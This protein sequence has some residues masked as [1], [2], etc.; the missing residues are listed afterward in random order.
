MEELNREK[1]KQY[2]KFKDLHCYLLFQLWVW[3]LFC[4]NLK[5][6][7][8]LPSGGEWHD[9]KRLKVISGSFSVAL[10]CLKEIFSSTVKLS[11][12]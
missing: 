5:K 9:N 11:T 1:R 6:A 3:F 10:S 4:F 8:V 12:M 2:E 7:V